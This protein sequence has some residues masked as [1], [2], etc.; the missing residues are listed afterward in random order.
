MKAIVKIFFILLIAF[1][2]GKNDNGN[3]DYN[4][5]H[6]E[7]P[8]VVDGK[9]I[10]KH[11]AEDRIF[12]VLNPFDIANPISLPIYPEGGKPYLGINKQV[13]MMFITAFLLILFFTTKRALDYKY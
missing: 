13:V 5:D 9:V 10:M 4:A 6:N 2:F 8:K 3:N 11:L 12:E 7:H 1:S